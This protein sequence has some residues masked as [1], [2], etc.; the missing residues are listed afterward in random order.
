MILIKYHSL[1]LIM[2]L[3]IDVHLC[4]SCSFDEVKKENKIGLFFSFNQNHILSKGLH[5]LIV[6]L[7][8]VANNA[9]LIYAFSLF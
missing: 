8:A 3:L 4:S 5:Q 1:L 9:L 6:I 7:L 2:Q